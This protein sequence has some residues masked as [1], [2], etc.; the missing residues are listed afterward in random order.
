MEVENGGIDPAILLDAIAR[1]GDNAQGGVR[2]ITRAIERQ[3]TDSI[4]DA[5]TLGASAIRLCAEGPIVRAEVAAIRRDQSAGHA[6]DPA[7]AA[8]A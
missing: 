5:N 6:L 3:I 1:F 7:M 2:D 8:R 4:I